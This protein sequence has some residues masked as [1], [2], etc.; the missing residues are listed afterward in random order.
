MH[1]LRIFLGMALL[2][3]AGATGF[4]VVSSL[5]ESADAEPH[6]PSVEIEVLLDAM[7]DGRPVVFVDVRERGEFEESRIPGAVHLPVRDLDASKLV[8]DHIIA[9][10]L[11]S[12][13]RSSP[14]PPP[15]RR[16][17]R[18]GRAV[19]KLCSTSDAQTTEEP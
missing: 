18:R 4:G 2:A 9:R 11:A 8:T 7:R 16:T 13:P 14:L 15:G 6:I 12:D 17:A 3:V 5:S 1:A 19:D 10:I